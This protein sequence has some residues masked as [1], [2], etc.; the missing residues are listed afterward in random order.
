[1]YVIFLRFS[2]KRVQAAQWLAGHRQWLQQGLDDGIFLA[3]GSLEDGKG[4]AIVATSVEQGALTARIEQDPFVVH[5]IVTPEVHAIA[6]SLVS[7][8]FAE[9]L[10]GAKP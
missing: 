6:P 7:P 5:G 2:P 10:S 8:G 9:L 1:M 4:G 3:A